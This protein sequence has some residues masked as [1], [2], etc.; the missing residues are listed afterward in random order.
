MNDTSGKFAAGVNYTCGKFATCIY[1]T[2]GTTGVI[3]NIGKFA[4]SVNN[5]G[6]RWQIMLAISDCLHLKVNLKK[7]IYLNSI[8]HRCPNKI[9]KTSLIEDFFHLPLCQQP[10]WCTWSCEYRIQNIQNG[11]MLYSGAWGKLIHEKTWSRK[12]LVALSLSRL[13]M[14]IL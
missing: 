9:F 8:I 3:D 14:A 10:W 6:H 5:T 2:G 7:K 11:P 13:R 4:T 1:D 12:N